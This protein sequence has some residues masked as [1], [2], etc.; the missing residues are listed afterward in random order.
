MRASGTY[1]EL[2]GG[3]RHMSTKAVP[4]SPVST[5]KQDFSKLLEQYG[6][7][8]IRFAGAGDAL[9]ERHILFDNAVDLAAA[10]SRDQ[11]EAA[12]RSVRDILSQRW[13]VTEKTYDRQNAKR[14]YYL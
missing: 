9:Y 4:A 14:L 11:F 12:A 5:A 1:V 6:C 7:G 10:T 2:S 13:V 3:S 8:P